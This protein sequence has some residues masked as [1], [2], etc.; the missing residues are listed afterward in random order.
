MMMVCG[1]PSP[2]PRE[3]VAFKR[4]TGGRTL[5]AK[6]NRGLPFAGP[7]LWSHRCLRNQKF[8]NQ[9]FYSRMPVNP[10]ST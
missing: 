6:G 10:P 4:P 3:V 8:Y 5:P 1:I 9:K 7:G 2:D